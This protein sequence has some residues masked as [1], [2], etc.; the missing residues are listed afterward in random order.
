M[1][2]RGITSDFGLGIPGFEVAEI[3]FRRDGDGAQ[4]I[5]ELRCRAAVLK[6]ALPLFAWGHMI[7]E[8]D[9]SVT[10]SIFLRFY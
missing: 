4:Y 6:G 1:T 5:P 7:L 8:A 2:L 10:L 3:E 9:S